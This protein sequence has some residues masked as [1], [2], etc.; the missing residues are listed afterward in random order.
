MMSA[1]MIL[2]IIAISFRFMADAAPASPAT[3]PATKSATAASGPMTVPA[4][5]LPASPRKHPYL[6]FTADELPALREKLKHEPFV[7]K[8]KLFLENADMLAGQDPDKTRYGAR[9]RNTLGVVGITAFAYAITGQEKYGQR[10]KREAMAMINGPWHRNYGWNRGANLQTAE[11]CVEAALFY[12]WCGDLLSDEERLTFREG[13]MNRGVRVYLRSLLEYHDWWVDNMTTNWDGVCHGGCGL[14]ALAFYDEDAEARAAADMAWEHVL[15][16]LKAVTRQDGGGDEGVM[17]WRYGVEF[18]HYLATAA[19]RVFGDDKGLFRDYADKLA[20]YWDAYMQASDGL[21]ANFNNMDERTFGLAPLGNA[22]QLEG[23]TSACLAALFESHVPGGD[24]LLLW[25]ADNGHSAFYF[26]GVSPFYFLW[27]RADAPQAEEKPKLQD[28]VLF[29]GN[30]HAVLQSA[31][32]WLAFNG[33]W[34]SDR[35]HFNCDLGTFILVSG[36]ERFVNDPGYGKWQTGEHSTILVNGKS[37]PKD[38]RAKYLRLGS[39]EGFHYLACDLSSCYD[40]DLSRFIRHLVMVDGRFIVILDDLALAEPSASRP[41]TAPTASRPGGMPFDAELDGPPDSPGPTPKD[42]KNPAASPTTTSATGKAFSDAPIF[43]SRIQSRQTI[44]LAADRP[45][46]V[47]R[48]TKGAMHILGA[49][50]ADAKL[51]QGRATLSY[52][53]IVPARKNREETF[54]T[55][56]YPAGLD[57]PA[58]KAGLAD[59]DGKSTLTITS[60]DGR[61][62]DKLVFIKSAGK[63]T[64]LNVNGKDASAVGDGSARSLV[65]IR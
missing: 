31:R 11:A 56:L 13:V 23:G 51:S 38:A 29:R 53:S 35:S 6:F 4:T 34:V 15:K 1:G 65:P 45:S 32:L 25:A 17:Y 8:W 16:F 60:P 3:T 39:G 52:I 9:S 12:D 33:G 64:L 57:E 59:A 7:S 21:Y 54:L 58:P 62:V 20:G 41:A 30:G 47:L 22:P 10:A 27:R 61:T 63:W 49:L 50:P 28:A 46:A 43:E 37:Q 2:G 42:Q 24:R 14:A 5:S 19:A 44:G 18:G 48:G 40:S 55:I 26:K 36:G